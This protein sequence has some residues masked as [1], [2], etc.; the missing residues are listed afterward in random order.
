MTEQG[1]V[2]WDSDRVRDGQ[3]GSGK[4]LDSVAVVGLIPYPLPGLDFIAQVYTD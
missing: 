3:V 4:G 2:E 1:R